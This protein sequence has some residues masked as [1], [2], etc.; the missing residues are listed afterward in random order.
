MLVTHE[1]RS[2][3]LDRLD[4]AARA[5]GLNDRQW[6]IAAG[7][8]ESYV[9]QQRHQARKD[10]KYRL[11]EDGAEALARAAKVSVP[12][13]RFGRGKM[14]DAPPEG[15][16]VEYTI[17]G[18]A[19]TLVRELDRSWTAAE[20][21]LIEASQRDPER[22]PAGAVLAALEAVRT[23]A[24]R[25]PDNRV[26]AAATMAHVL[27]AAARLT[28]EGK[29]FTLDDLL[30]TAVSRAAQA[31]D[32]AEGHAQLAALGG[33]APREPVRTPARGMPVAPVAP[34]PDR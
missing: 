9:K 29:P 25:L 17:P 1:Q 28:R 21:A 4:A 23:G 31:D 30:W 6:S 32:N 26:A 8:S 24:A 11:P 33:V 22:Y 13:L 10:P 15:A 19:R 7:L 16:A 2:P 34:K 27:D 3:L 5:R 14:D 20:L 12:W 18:P